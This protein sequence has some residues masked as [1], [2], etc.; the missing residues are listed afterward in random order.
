VANALKNPGSGARVE[1]APAVGVQLDDGGSRLLRR[2]I[3]ALAC[4]C[5]PA[6]PRDRR[7][8]DRRLRMN[9]PTPATSRPT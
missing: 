9:S 4:A 6:R 1:F 8:R 5:T 2:K 3:E 7:R